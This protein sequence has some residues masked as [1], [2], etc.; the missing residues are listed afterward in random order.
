MQKL[1]FFL[2]LFFFCAASFSQNKSDFI[3][4]AQEMG[5]IPSK[6]YK[7]LQ[8]SIEKVHTD[9]KIE[10]LRIYTKGENEFLLFCAIAKSSNQNATGFIILKKEKNNLVIPQP[11][12]NNPMTGGGWCIHSDCGACAGNSGSCTPIGEVHYDEAAGG[13]TVDDCFCSEPGG[14]CNK[15]VWQGRMITAIIEAYQ[16]F[17]KKKS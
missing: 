15:V 5:T 13:M 12:M 2:L 16:T 9:Y 6:T 14:G 11:K 7:L 3:I 8:K 17:Q 4:V 1:M 10:N